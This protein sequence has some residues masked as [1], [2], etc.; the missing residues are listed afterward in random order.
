MKT[1]ELALYKGNQ[2]IVLP[3]EFRFEGDEVRIQKSGDS[4]MVFP[5]P[6]PKF[7]TFAEFAQYLA[8]KYP[9]T[10]PF[11]EPLPQLPNQPGPPLDW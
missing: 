3:D 6:N 8:Q 5:A 10:E 1:A 9:D 7:N 2:V 11:P 4:L